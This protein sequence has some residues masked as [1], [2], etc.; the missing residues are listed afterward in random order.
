MSD[1]LARH[2]VD[3]VDVL[4]RG[5]GRLARGLDGVQVDAVR[6][7]VRAARRAAGPS[8]GATSA[9]RRAARSR[10]HCGRAHGPVVEG[11]VEHAHVTGSPRSGSRATW[12][13][14]PGHRGPRRCVLHAGEHGRPAPAWPGA[15]AVARRPPGD[16]LQV[17]DPHRA[18]DGGAQD[19]AVARG[20]DG[21]SPGVGAIFDLTPCLSACAPKRR[22]AMPHTSSRTPGKPSAEWILRSTVS[23]VVV[24]PVDGAVGRAHERP[25]RPRA[26]AP[27]SAPARACSPR[28]NFATASLTARTAASVTSRRY[29]LDLGASRIGKAAW[30]HTGPASISRHGLQH[31]D[32][33]LGLALQDR[34]VERRWA[35]VAG[36]AGVHHEAR[37]AR[38]ERS[39]IARLRN[40]AIDEV[41][42]RERHGLAR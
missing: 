12:Q 37:H 36:H 32:A 27:R 31:R 22:T 40:G 13:A 39:G 8:S 24:R 20:D 18:V 30:A 33:P 38:P 6:P 35:A 4:P 42:L 10:W 9:W 29:R 17:R 26:T 14:R 41:G 15:S 21:R 28:A 25:P 7:E 11:E 3:G 23:V 34:P 1:D 19:G 16:R 5:V 2:V